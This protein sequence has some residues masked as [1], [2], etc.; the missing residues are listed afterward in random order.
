MSFSFVKLGWE[1]N[2]FVFL[3]ERK[4]KEP[5]LKD[6]PSPIVIAVRCHRHPNQKNL[7]D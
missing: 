2:R 1:K 4:S 6:R 7:T 3:K 5:E